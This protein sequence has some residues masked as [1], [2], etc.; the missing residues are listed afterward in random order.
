M[1]RSSD[2]EVRAAF[3]VR[4]PSLLWGMSATSAGILLHTRLFPFSVADSV[5]SVPLLKGPLSPALRGPRSPPVSGLGSPFGRGPPPALRRSP[6][7]QQPFEGPPPAAGRAVPSA[8]GGPL[9]PPLR[10][11]LPSPLVLLPPFQSVVG[12]PGAFPPL[13][14]GPPAGAVGHQPLGLCL[15]P[16]LGRPVLG[17]ASPAVGGPGS[18]VPRVVLTGLS[19]VLSAAFPLVPVRPLF[20]M[21]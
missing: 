4:S 12:A 7:I 6:L 3:F 10:R 11:T 18:S 15:P 20:P 8:G 2:T 9:S 21:G 13:L 16:P 19:A 1:T 14:R 17:S 5:L